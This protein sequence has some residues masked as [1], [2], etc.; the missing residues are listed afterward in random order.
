ML[1]TIHRRL[2]TAGFVISIVALVVALGGGAYAASGGL[3]GKQKK[4][5]EKIAKK[6]A[7]KPGAEGKQGPAG[8]TGTGGAVGK[9]GAKGM[10]GTNGTNGMN[11]TKGTD[12][13]EGPP[14]PTCSNT[15]ECLLPSGATESGAWSIPGF[16]LKTSFEEVFAP[17]TFPLKLSFTPTV[18]FV[19]TA[20]ASTPG[21]VT[22]CPGTR[23]E[24]KAEAGKL[25]VYELGGGVEFVG[26][27][28]APA[29]DPKSGTVLDFAFESGETE[30]AA[31]GSWAVK[32]P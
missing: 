7:G 26:A 18:L 25:C 6:Y 31:Y 2:G 14:G 27:I 13:K 3:T 21:A 23:A 15:G 32:A 22:G 1:S 19:P 5:V 29:I 12:G 30:G 28:G 20:E 17:I 10:D 9:D 11:G 8:P 4:E 16:V 24:P